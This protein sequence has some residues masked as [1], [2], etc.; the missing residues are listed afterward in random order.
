[1]HDE[2]D[3]PRKFYKLKDAEFTRVN[4]PTNEPDASDVHAVLRANLDKANAAG[5]NELTEQKRR[6]SRRK[7]DYWFLL[8]IGNAFFGGALAY[9]GL[10]S[11]PGMFGL[12]GMFFFTFALTFVMWFVMD[13]Y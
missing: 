4:Q 2:P 7:R 6:P 13:N 11:I 3:P 9:F 10:R 8:I 12:G 5:L 1:M